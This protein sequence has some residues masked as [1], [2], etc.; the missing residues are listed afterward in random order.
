MGTALEVGQALEDTFSGLGH[1]VWLNAEFQP[2]QLTQNPDE[3]LLL[4][5]S[6][7]GMGDL[8]ANIAPLWVH[9]TNDYPAISGRRYGLINL[10]DSSYPNFAQA[11]RTLDEAMA[12]LGA[13]R[14]GDPLVL[15]ANYLVDPAD[16]A[17]A[18]ALEWEQ[19]L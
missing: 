5:T 12:D 13:Q 10:G 3:V 1:N 18:W 4:C 8:P 19:K 7:T 15:D 2:G 16:E 17:A 9:L 11:G 14:L 6:N